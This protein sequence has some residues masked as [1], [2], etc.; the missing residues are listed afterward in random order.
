MPQA[1]AIAGGRKGQHIVA[2]SL[3]RPAAWILAAFAPMAVAITVLLGKAVTW[4][5]PDA[6]TPARCRRSSAN[7]PTRPD[8][9]A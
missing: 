6:A 8:G 4:P 9:S 3:S 5:P 7:V 2:T 1:T